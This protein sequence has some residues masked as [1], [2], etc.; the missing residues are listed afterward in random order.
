MEG[1][2]LLKKKK[3]GFRCGLKKASRWMIFEITPKRRER[4]AMKILGGSASQAGRKDGSLR[5]EGSGVSDWCEG[6]A[7]PRGE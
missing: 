3:S 2:E 6:K 5:L 1:L 7:W 4:K